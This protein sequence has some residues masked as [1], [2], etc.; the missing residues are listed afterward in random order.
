MEAGV[1]TT[2]APLISAGLSGSQGAFKGTIFTLGA[3]TLPPFYTWGDKGLEGLTVLPSTKR[4][5]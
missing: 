5:G 2:S 1:L 4:L 3:Y